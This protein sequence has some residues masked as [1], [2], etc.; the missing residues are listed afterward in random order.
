MVQCTFSQ[1]DLQSRL[2]AV[3]HDHRKVG[4]GPPGGG[5]RIAPGGAAPP[6][7]LPPHHGEAVGQGGAGAGHKVAWEDVQRGPSDR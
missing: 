1:Y 2:L 7:A 4:G 3:E 6:P 5:S